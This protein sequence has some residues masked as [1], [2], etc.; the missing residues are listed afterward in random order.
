MIVNK[1]KLLC[2]ISII[3]LSEPLGVYSNQP[4][5][6]I[7]SVFKIIALC[8][9][10]SLILTKKIKI[11]K[12][13]LLII[14]WGIF[15]IIPTIRMRGDLRVWFREF[16]MY[17]SIVIIAQY[18]MIKDSGYIVKITSIFLCIVLIINLLTLYILGPDIVSDGSFGGNGI[19]YLIGGRIR[20]GDWTIIAMT[21]SALYGIKRK[22]YGFI[23]KVTTICATIFI[24][25][26]WVST[27]ILCVIV[28]FILIIFIKNKKIINLLP[29][30]TF[31]SSGIMLVCILVFKIQEKFSWLIIGILGED[32]SLNGRID[33]WTVVVKQIK[34]SFFIG[35]GYGT[36]R[37]F[38]F[39]E[40]QFVNK[41][42]SATHNQYLAWLYDGGIISLIMCIFI[43]YM[44][45]LGLKR[46]TVYRIRK[47][48]SVSMVVYF[49]LMIPEVA[50]N[51][52]IFFLYITII[53]NSCY[54]SINK[55][56][57][58]L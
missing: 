40:S 22:Y 16:Y 49:I 38:K 45:I 24:L 17:T 39:Y 44:T 3:G 47:L 7:F 58:K 56:N 1:D 37:I 18:W 10:I 27:S 42:T 12:F 43:I 41:I 31:I 26:N 28:F 34:N 20:I 14:L 8:Y 19:N 57:F 32:L 2:V 52:S 25:K 46:C 6:A 50:C 9:A 54:F 11:D 23:F 35:H 51:N 5:H 21:M 29:L 33:I 4:I 15:M 53:R 48:L 30:I 55:N 13:C 36:T